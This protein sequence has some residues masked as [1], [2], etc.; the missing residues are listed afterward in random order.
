MHALASPLQKYLQDFGGRTTGQEPQQ[1]SPTKGETV[2][3]C[4][5][6]NKASKIFRLASPEHVGK[7]SLEE[8]EWQEYTELVED[9]SSSPGPPLRF[10]SQNGMIKHG[11]CCREYDKAF[12]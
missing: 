5:K 9:F 7:D 10:L 11:W 4:E 3:I 12:L 1:L 2:E 8:P 6:E